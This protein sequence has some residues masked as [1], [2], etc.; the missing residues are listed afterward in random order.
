MLKP[1]M[2]IKGLCEIMLKSW[3]ILIYRKQS[4]LH[5]LWNC[6]R[7]AAKKPEIPI[8]KFVLF[9]TKQLRCSWHRHK[10]GNLLY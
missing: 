7:A 1:A 10:E 4:H 9:R 2:P 8:Q 5:L 3:H 6:I